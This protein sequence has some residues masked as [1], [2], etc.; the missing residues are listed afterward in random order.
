MVRR[1]TVEE[2][3]GLQDY[4]DDQEPSAHTDVVAHGSPQHAALLG[5]E[6]DPDSKLGYR[7]S[8]PTTYGPNATAEFLQRILEQRVRELTTPMP[9]MQSKKRSAPFYAPPRWVPRG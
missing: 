6:P 7:L 3:D 1:A 8:D 5:L 9:K 4:Y 2:E